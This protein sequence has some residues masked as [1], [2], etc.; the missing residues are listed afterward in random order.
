MYSNTILHRTLVSKLLIL[1][2]NK[3]SITNVYVFFKTITGIG[4]LSPLLSVEIVHFVEGSDLFKISKLV[5][6][7]R[8][9][10]RSV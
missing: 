8:E 4:S 3:P 6:D 7:G 1:E 10:V 9:I 2:K 5:Y